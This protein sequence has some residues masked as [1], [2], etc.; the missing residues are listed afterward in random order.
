MKDTVNDHGQRL[1]GGGKERAQIQPGFLR[2]A[3]GG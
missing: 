1:R 2:D 3:S